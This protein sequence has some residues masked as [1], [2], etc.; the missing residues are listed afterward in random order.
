MTAAIDVRQ[1]QGKRL[2]HQVSFTALSQM[3]PVLDSTIVRYGF[4]GTHENL[5]KKIPL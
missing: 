4:L 1:L 3:Q 5:M 2:K